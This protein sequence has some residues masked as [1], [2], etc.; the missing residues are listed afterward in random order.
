MAPTAENITVTDMPTEHPLR[1]LYNSI[2]SCFQCPVCEKYMS[3]PIGQCMLGH[4]FCSNCLNNTNLCPIC[5]GRL[6]NGRCFRLETIHSLLIV[7]CKYHEEGCTFLG[8]EQALVI[9]HMT[10]KYASIPCPLAGNIN[11]YI[12]SLGACPWKGTKSDVLAHCEQAHPENAL[13]GSTHL[14]TSFDFL[15]ADHLVTPI[16][17]E[18]FGK[19]F[20]LSYA[21]HHE[22]DRVAFAVHCLD[23]DEATEHFR[24]EIGFF[25]EGSGKEVYAVRSPCY[26]YGKDMSVDEIF[27]SGN[28]VIMFYNTVAKWCN[29]DGDLNQSTNSSFEFSNNAKNNNLLKNYMDL[30]LTM[31]IEF[32]TIKSHTIFPTTT[33][34]N[35]VRKEEIL[36]AG[37]TMVG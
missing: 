14:L 35:V 18:A 20:K 8:Q 26:P 11:S 2:L 23:D 34:Y 10:C 31:L 30:Y 13:I 3:P 29:Q 28:C 25:E 7:Q 36:R 9:H 15:R 19:L 6:S 12:P 32:E 22:A 16:L 33:T 37:F 4:N 17:I 1:D 27:S 21:M 5:N 24:F